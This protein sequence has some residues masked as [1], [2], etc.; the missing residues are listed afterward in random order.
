MSAKKRQVQSTTVVPAKVSSV[1]ETANDTPLPPPPPVTALQRMRRVN[2]LTGALSN[3]EFTSFVTKMDEGEFLLQIFAEAVEDE[4]ETMFQG[5]DKVR[6][7]MS[8]LIRSI[9]VSYAKVQA[10]ASS[11][12]QS[13]LESLLAKLGGSLQPQQASVPVQGQTFNNSSLEASRRG[14]G[15]MGF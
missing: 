9:D 10:M 2:A 3:K 15:I 14:D 12:L 1:L 5:S 13:V 6:E 4:L 11:P 7:S 8:T